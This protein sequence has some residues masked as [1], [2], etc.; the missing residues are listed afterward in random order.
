MSVTTKSKKILSI[1]EERIKQIRQIRKII[2]RY[3]QNLELFQDK[4]MHILKLKFIEMK[5]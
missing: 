4:Q 5:I 1:L 3:L 2:S